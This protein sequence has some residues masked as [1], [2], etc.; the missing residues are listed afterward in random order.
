MALDCMYMGASEPLI[1][2][3]TYY[4]MLTI[5]L[6]NIIFAFILHLYLKKKNIL[7][8]SDKIRIWGFFLT[9]G[10]VEMFLYPFG[11]IGIIY[12]SLFLWGHLTEEIA[13]IFISILILFTIIL[14]INI[15]ICLLIRNKAL[16]THEMEFQL[17][18]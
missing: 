4:M 11:E 5:F 18:N 12:R 2:K 6:I 14:T 16:K 1:S 8:E 3:I 10:F 15:F 7:Y 13:L 9:A 17:D